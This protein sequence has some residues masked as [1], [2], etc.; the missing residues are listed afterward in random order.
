MEALLP[1]PSPWDDFSRG[2]E[3]SETINK[4]RNI[5]QKKNPDNNQYL[6]AD[7]DYKPQ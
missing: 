3:V 4:D 5:E 7:D 6:H 1:W 2:N